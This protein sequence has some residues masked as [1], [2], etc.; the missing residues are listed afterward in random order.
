MRDVLYVIFCVLIAMIG[1]TIHHSFGWA[2]VDFFFAPIALCKW[3]ICKQITM[4]IIKL[5]FSWFFQ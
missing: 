1:Y 2:I 5:T 3:L 4:S